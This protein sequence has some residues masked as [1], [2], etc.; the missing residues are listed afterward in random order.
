MTYRLVPLLRLV[1]PVSGLQSLP[2]ETLGRE[3]VAFARADPPEGV[4]VF[5]GF[6]PELF[7][8]PCSS[9]TIRNR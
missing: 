4:Q 8:G 3:A 6:V 7:D 5:P 2:L 1:V 9:L